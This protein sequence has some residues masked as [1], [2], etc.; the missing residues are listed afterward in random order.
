MQYMSTNLI[1]INDTFCLNIFTTKGHTKLNV[2][3]YENDSKTNKSF[4]LL[5]IN[6]EFSV[7]AELRVP[8][9]KRKRGFESDEVISPQTVS[10]YFKYFRSVI[11]EHMIQSKKLGKIGGPGHLMFKFSLP[12]S[13]NY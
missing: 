4:S 3:F 6:F 7:Q 10:K 12:Y 11:A 8:S 5:I 13:M 2:A 9:G 1:E